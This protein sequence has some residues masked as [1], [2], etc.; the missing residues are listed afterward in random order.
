M[1]KTTVYFSDEDAEALRQL[2][3]ATGTSQAEL[4]RAAVRRA[5]AEAPE[6]QFRSL[7][8]GATSDRQPRRWSSDALYDKA[9]GRA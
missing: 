9:F 1:R 3:A 8:R 4:I 5:T 7:G 6:R 2:A